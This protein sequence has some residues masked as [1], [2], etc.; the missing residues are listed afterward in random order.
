MDKNE[1]NNRVNHSSSF[2]FYGLQ[3]LRLLSLNLCWKNSLRLVPKEVPPKLEHKAE[4][5]VGDRSSWYSYDYKLIFVKEDGTTE[6]RDVSISQDNPTPLVPN[7]YVKAT[8]SIKRV[9][10]GPNRIDEQAIPQKL[11]K[12]RTPL[13]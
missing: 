6:I 13:T 10:K 5:S 7:S 1:K 8:I 4:T 11:H 2:R 9:R 3:S 12:K